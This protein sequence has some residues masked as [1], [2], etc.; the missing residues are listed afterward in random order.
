MKQFFLYSCMVLCPGL[1][2]AQ[3]LTLHDAVAIALQN[4][5][6]IQIAKNNVTAAG[7]YNS[8]GIAGG[9]PLVTASGLDQEQSTS[10]KQEYA[11]PANNKSSSNASSNSLSASLNASMLLYNGNR[12]QNARKRL[13]TI[14][15]QNQQVLSS[16]GLMVA[17]NVMLR[18]YDIIRQ[19]SY[20]GTLATSIT[21]SRQKLDIVKAQQSAGVA[22]NADLFQAQV[23]LNTQIQNLQAQQLVID[24][25]KTDLLTLLT[26]K[27]DSSVTIQDTI[28]VDK[29]MELGT[30]LNAIASNPDITAADEQVAINE[31]LEK[32]TAAQ[33]YPSLSANAGYNFSHT[34][35]AAGFSLLNQSYGP[36]AGVGV[37]IPIFNGSIYRK[38]QQVADIN[39]KNARLQKDTLTLNY[40]SNTIKNWQAYNN[41]LQQLE[42]A[43]DNY[44]LSGKLLALVLQRFQLKQATIVDVKN[45]Q[46]S[47]E[48]AG[49]LLV[50]VSFSAKAAEL[51]LKWYAHNLQY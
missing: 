12:V 38:Q 28:L 15:A 4:S 11:N 36:F 3:T 40:T 32:E 17:Y 26:L 27:P 16:R 49:Y 46:E 5:L 7:I 48:N 24:Q 30:V 6:G 2:Q 25:A 33:R 45:A 31:Y 35:N 13:G 21:V 1:L 42:T 47:F 20:A 23:D 19:Q 14:E 29:N 9:L 10:I 37:S 18:Y 43:K 8:Y 50:N 44:D 39:I 34:K 51:R 22:N 41:N